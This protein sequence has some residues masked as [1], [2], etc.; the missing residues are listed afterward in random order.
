MLKLD[1]LGDREKAM[2]SFAGLALCG[3]LL[4]LLALPFIKGVEKIESECWRKDKELDY[5]LSLVRSEK[6]VEDDFSKV[7]AMLSVSLSDAESISNMKEELEDM[8]RAA[9]LTF[10]PPSHREPVA[11]ASLPWREYVVELPKCEGTMESMVAF[12]GLLEESPVVYRVERMSLAPSKTPD[13]VTAAIVV[14]RIML[15]PAQDQTVTS[16]I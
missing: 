3:M 8:A 4:S 5:A 14:S 11:D 16:D 15:P 9:G 2:L 1:N 13:A 10:E 7:E 6:A 12:V